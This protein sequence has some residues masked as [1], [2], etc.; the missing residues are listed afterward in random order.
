MSTT[1]ISNLRHQRADIVAKANSILT[2]ANGVSPEQQAEVERMLA[3]SDTLGKTIAMAERA[4][5][6]DRELSADRAIV[7]AATGVSA[8][9]Q[10]NDIAQEKRLFAAF[11]CGAS[12]ML[13]AADRAVLQARINAAGSVGSSG[14]GGY[15]V[16]P[17]FQRDLLIAQ[18][19]F[20]G[21]RA[22]SREI[23][24]STGVA[25]PWP[26]MDDTNNVASIVG[27][28]TTGVPGPDLNFGTTSINAYM[29]RSGIL[30][31][32]RELLMDSAF[33]FD[34]L[35]NGAL[36]QRF[37]R[38]QNA[39]F[40]NGTGVGQPQGVVTAAPVGTTGAAGQT[41][42]VTLDDLINLEHS[43]DPA[44]RPGAI[45]MM[46]DSTVKAMRKLK[47]STGRPLL[48]NDADA[49]AS[50]APYLTL[51]GSPVQINQDM[52]VMA[53]GAKSILFGN[54]QNYIIRDVLG[55]EITRLNELLA[56][57]GQVGFIGFA[58]ADGRLVSAVSPIKAYAHP[59]T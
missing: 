21:M 16:A 41:T 23:S 4:D 35:V 8:D 40:T 24:T 5:A 28:N 6:L 44:Y 38:G 13:N 43:I 10:E 59:A 27:E 34:S 56:A 18:K 57:N 33:P 30:A 47:D 2:N 50:G 31:V 49:L 51:N 12:N 7:H 54:F 26:T 36:A 22:V 53:A 1:H 52:P 3:D 32:S 55:V 42:S 15:L 19:A 17:G 25:L 39:H 29:Y 11:V 14:N 48:W 45:Y 20:G 58:R 9:K 46:H 37:A